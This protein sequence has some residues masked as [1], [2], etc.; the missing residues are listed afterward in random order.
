MTRII[1]LIL[2]VL[3]VL[4]CFTACNDSSDTPDTGN[5]EA[6]TQT[7]DVTG[8]SGAA[9]ENGQQT[10]DTDGNV[11]GDHML[12]GKKIIFV[13]N[14]HTYYGKNVI[15]KKQTVLTQ[16]AR[17]NDK[18]Y[19][20][21][22][23]KSNGAE[24]SV[25]N[26]TFG[27]HDFTDLFENCTANRGCDGVDHL[28]YLVDRSFDYVVLQQ[29]SGGK[30]DTDFVNT[31]NKVMNIFRA[32]NPN[33]RFVL[34]VQRSAHFD[35]YVW[36]SS[37]KELAAQGVTIVDWGA[38][39]DDI[40]NG[41]V[42]V[43]GAKQTYNKNSFI[44]CKSADDGYHPNMLTGYITSLMTYCALTGEDAEGQDYS[45]C[46]NTKISNNFSFTKFISSYYTYNGATTNFTKIFESADDMKG[47]QQLVDRYLEEK[48]YMNY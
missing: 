48:A 29:G 19:F 42:Q 13:G 23:C 37:I 14:S 36:L 10:D 17:S 7:S 30:D 43:P 6:G 12:D 41:K 24:V 38:L 46:G 4:V 28:S 26:W 9:T 21:Q 40:I 31:C 22:L 3:M 32:A 25:T 34:L 16:E 20:Y 5:S 45:F 27:A 8:D 18:G 35:N 2:T 44:V 39:V 11:S 47:I 15:E 33:V 1:A